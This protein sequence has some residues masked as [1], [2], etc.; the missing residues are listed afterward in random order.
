MNPLVNKRIVITRAQHQINPF[1]EQL[2]Q[3]GAIP[4]VFPCLE[5]VPQ[6]AQSLDDALLTLHQFD[7]LILTSRN[8]VDILQSRLIPINWQTINVAAV[9]TSTAAAF[10]QAFGL[11]VD[12]IPPTYTA[13]SLGEHIPI[14][15]G[16]RIFLPQSALAKPDLAECLKTRGAT[17]KVIHAYT[18]INGSGG[19]DI[20]GMLKDGLIDAI[21]FMSPSSITNFL[22]RV[23]PYTQY[24]LETLAVCIGDVTAQAAQDSKF[25]HIIMADEYTLNGLINILET[26][27]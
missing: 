26:S 21:T 19:D 15:G 17:V 16:E 9:G 11:D 7:W 27:L 2:Q 6:N 25:R 10:K 23:H 18:V 8:T 20:S 1:A 24:A 4:I 13:Q 5:L 12:F 22:V 3:R 14:N